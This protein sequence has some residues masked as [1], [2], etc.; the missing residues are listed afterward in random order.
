MSVST[1]TIAVQVHLFAR[2]AEVLGAETVPMSLP[3][4]STLRDVVERIRA[5]PG[6]DLL[7]PSPLV[8]RNMHQES[9][10]TSLDDGDEVALLP[11]LAGG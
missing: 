5:L 3:A 2:Y 1:G 11:P 6:G 10:D 7:P 8:A 4:G 9:Y